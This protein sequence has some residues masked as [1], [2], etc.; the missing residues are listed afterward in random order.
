MPPFLAA[1]PPAFSRVAVIGAGAA[2]LVAAR[3]LRREGLRVV[4]FERDAA[5]GGTWVYTPATESDPLGLDPGRDIVLSSLYDSLRTNLPRES[6]GF[7][8]YPFSSRRAPDGADTRRFPGHRE[9]LRYVQD[10][11]RDFDLYGLVRF[12]REVERVERDQDGRWQVDSRCVDYGGDESEVFDGVV[13][14]NGHFTQPRIAEIPGICY[15]YLPI[16]RR[17]SLNSKFCR[18]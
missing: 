1:A 3:E 6:M 9:V 12:H 13:V 17:H 10:F 14:C 15:P 8:D 11:A 2:G 16:S 5:I 18:L 4:V 7:L